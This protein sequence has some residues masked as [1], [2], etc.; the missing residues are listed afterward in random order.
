MTD[1]FAVASPSATTIMDM[2]DEVPRAGTLFA[3]DSHAPAAEPAGEKFAR[4]LAGPSAMQL[5]V[6]VA[7]LCCQAP[8]LEVTRPAGMAPWRNAHRKRS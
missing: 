1:G 5:I 7:G 3:P 2:A 8:A 4:H 6:E